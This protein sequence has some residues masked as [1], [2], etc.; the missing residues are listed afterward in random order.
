MLP[1][2]DDRGATEQDGQ[3]RDVV[4][5]SDDA[6]EPAR[7]GVRIERQPDRERDR[8]GSD[9][10][11]A[12]QAAPDCRLDDLLHV[13][14]ADAGLHCGRCIDVDLHGRLPAGLYV[15]VHGVHLWKEAIV[16]GDPLNNGIPVWECV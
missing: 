16:V 1:L 15:P 13:T 2:A 5:D 3:H 6:H 11:G 10:I 8:V 14:G 9:V 7:R 4:D 12:R